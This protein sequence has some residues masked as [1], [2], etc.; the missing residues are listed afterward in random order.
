M[1]RPM[2]TEDWTG[3]AEI[4]ARGIIEGNS[5]FNRVCP[6]YEKWD[7]GH[8]P[9]CRFVYE[10]DGTVEGWITVCP[11]SG[12]DAYRG[13]VEVSLYVD[14][15]FRGRSIGPALMKHLISEAPK[16]GI[17]SLLSVICSVNTHSIHMHEKCGFRTIGTRERIAKDRFD[18]WQD[19]TL[20][21]LRL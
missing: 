16:Y 3:V 21:E 11:T 14:K 1:I 6:P 19:T 15:A 13:S 17:W 2:L 10:I 20:M 12:M 4:Y 9:F 8:L 7:A 5:T 18:V